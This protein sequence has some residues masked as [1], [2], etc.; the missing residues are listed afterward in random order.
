MKW[1]EATTT[2]KNRHTRTEQNRTDINAIATT[3]TASDSNQNNSIRADNW[4]MTT[5]E[6]QSCIQVQN[7]C[8]SNQIAI[9]VLQILL[10][11]SERCRLCTCTHSTDNPRRE[12]R[13]RE[14]EKKAQP[15]NEL[16]MRRAAK[17]HNNEEIEDER[18]HTKHTLLCVCLKVSKLK[19]RREHSDEPANAIKSFGM[20]CTE[21]KSV[22]L[23]FGRIWSKLSRLKSANVIAFCMVCYV[24]CA[25]QPANFRFLFFQI[26][27]SHS[28]FSLAIFPTMPRMT[29]DTFY[30]DD[31]NEFR[32]EIHER[33][34][35]NDAKIK[36]KFQWT[37][38]GNFFIFFVFLSCDYI[39]LCVD[40]SGKRCDFW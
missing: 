24:H 19:Y 5:R 18:A 25:A 10:V 30:R 16:K 23:N 11:S 8:I 6:I 27:F 26:F 9:M 2:T 29:G 14:K 36:P 13:E 32:C 15:N 33:H 21:R 38:F 28:A 35:I 34:E 12:N 17:T 22:P 31:T 4:T 1:I 40:L 3:T 37:I 20:C 7:C 39:I